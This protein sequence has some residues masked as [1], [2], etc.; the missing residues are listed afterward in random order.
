MKYQKSFALVSQMVVL[1]IAASLY[2]WMIPMGNQ[3]P[4][5]A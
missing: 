4:L 2:A 1:F 3:M 5:V